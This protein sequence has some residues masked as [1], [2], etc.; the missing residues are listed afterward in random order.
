[1][2]IEFKI[3]RWHRSIALPNG[4]IYLIGGVV[5]ISSNQETTSNMTYI[6]DFEENTLHPLKPMLIPRSG[7]GIAY[8]NEYIYCVGGFTNENVCSVK[9]EKYCVTNNVWEIIADLNY[10][11]NNACICSFQNRYLYKF[12]GKLAEKELNNYI[13]R[14]CPI[15]NIWGIVHI[16][17]EYQ[18]N[19]FTLLSS[20]ACCQINRNQILVFGGTYE[21]Y[22]QKSNQSFLIEITNQNEINKNKIL[23]NEEKDIHILKCINEKALPFS[24]GFWNNNPLIF[25][26]ELYCLQNIPNKNNLNIVYNDRR[27]ILKFDSKGNW[28]SYN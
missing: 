4:S 14:Y 21:D 23:N 17:S 10:E 1:M 3:P 12:G 19:D 8:L 18:L 22:S 25:N 11:A 27:R 5:A 28:V 13:E 26:S 2:N 20:A 6:Y 15:E 9:C 24:E 16:K 7:H